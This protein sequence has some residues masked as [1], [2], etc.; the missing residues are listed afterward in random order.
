MD[1]LIPDFNAKFK[2][3]KALLQKVKIEK[4][5]KG[6]TE[7]DINSY[8]DQLQNLCMNYEDWFDDKEGRNRKK[9]DED[10]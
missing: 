2:D 9:K 3:M 6:K 8:I 5:K 10:I 1:K 4:I 7:E